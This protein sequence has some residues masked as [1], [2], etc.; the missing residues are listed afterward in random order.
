MS[1]HYYIILNMYI[2]CI[3]LYT[4]LWCQ[5]QF[6]HKAC[7]HAV[8]LKSCTCSPPCLHA[9]K[10]TL[11]SVRT[12]T[13]R[14]FNHMHAANP[15]QFAQKRELQLCLMSLKTSQCHDRPAAVP[16][17]LTTALAQE[18][19]ARPQRNTYHFGQTSIFDH[20]HKTC[21]LLHVNLLQF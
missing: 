11:S 6:V 13:V 5:A 20:H 9:C 16:C 21:C 8:L 12:G 18:N 4:Y 1:I 17:L 3:I 15:F 7:W 19:G 2:I 14:R 10:P